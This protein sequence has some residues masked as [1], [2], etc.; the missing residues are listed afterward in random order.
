MD[1]RVGSQS[2]ALA[3]VRP[4]ELSAAQRIDT[5]EDLAR[6]RA[7]ADAQE[8]HLLSAMAGP[9]DPPRSLRDPELVDKQYVREEIACVLRLAPSSVNARLHV[10]DELVRRLPD[11]LAAL[12][13]GVLGLPYARCLAEAVGPLSDAV[14]ALVEK[15]VLPAAGRQT[16]RGFRESVARAL[17]AV[18]PRTA[19]EQHNDALADR[20]VEARMLDHG[21][22]SVHAEL[23]ADEVQ[24]IMTRVQAAADAAHTADD[25]RTADQ[26]RAD[27]FVSLLLGLDPACAATWQGRRPSVQVS[28][29][30]STLLHLD[31]EPGDLD[32]YGPVPATLAR[33]LAADPSGTWRRLV[34]DPMGGVIDVGRDAYQPPQDLAD[35]VI[36]RDRICRYPGCRRQA[37]R[38]DIDHQT[39]WEHGGQTDACNI[40]CLCPRHHNLKHETGWT[41]LGDP[42]GELTWIAPTGHTYLDPPGRHPIDRTGP[43]VDDECPF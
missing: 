3:P 21:M 17:I 35:H 38:C 23:A 22:A 28:V 26:R 6:L 43:A 24:A 33:R 31:D 1:I 16:L 20:R 34:T 4:A 14:A 36:A 27:A 40:E 13:R 25:G 9:G 5:L 7:W 15:R 12:E 41:V 8:Q 11:T 37:K 18:D 30:L 39:S 32:G 2:V 29:A 42:S 19:D 10:A